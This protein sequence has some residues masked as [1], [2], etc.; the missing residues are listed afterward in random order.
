MKNLNSKKSLY[1]FARLIPILIIIGVT[2]YMV[3]TKKD[4][5]AEQILNYTPKNVYLAVLFIL[6]MYAFK[7]LSFVFPIAAIQIAS[8]YIFNV[9]MALAINIIG[10]AISL[11]IPYW[12]GRFSGSEYADKLVEKHKKLEVLDNFQRSN[13]FFFSFIARVIG[14]LPVDVV[15]MYMGSCKIK[16]LQYVL[17]GVL[18]FM[19]RIIATT[20]MGSYITDMHSPAFIISFLFN[21]VLAIV[22]IVIYK[23]KLEKKKS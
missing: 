7:S 23:L 12:F 6:F 18:G 14:V 3:I 19:P 20:V 16:Y 9:Y 4:I 2:L 21:I 15:S 13:N 11:S 8:G 1:V 17:G 10:T 22:C 5:S